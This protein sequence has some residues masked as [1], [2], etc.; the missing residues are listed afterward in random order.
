MRGTA[1]RRVPWFVGV[2]VLLAFGSMLRYPG[3][4]PLNRSSDGYSLSQNFLSDLGM[5]VAYDGRSNALGALL[6]VASL[7]V[8]VV[9]LGGALFGFVRLYS[10]PARGRRWARA[11]GVVGLASCVAFTGVALTPENR[12]MSL[13]VSFTMLAWRIIPAASLLLAVASAH[14]S[15]VPRGI[16]ALWATLTIILLAYVLLIGW[17]PSV[18]TAEGLRVQVIAQKAIA[19]IVVG[20]LTYLSIAAERI[21]AG[22]RHD[23]RRV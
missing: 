4:T 13:H 2:A 19:T 20:A 21:S 16:V 7:C 8:L 11:A 1:F 17:G 22:E 5:T 14:S 6:F 9:G 12:V 18:G 23:T 3:G 15:V 10:Q